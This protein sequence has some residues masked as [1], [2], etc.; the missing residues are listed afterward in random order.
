MW[1]NRFV[2]EPLPTRVEGLTKAKSTK[3]ALTRNHRRIASP[4]EGAAVYRTFNPGENKN[5]G[6][7]SKSFN[8][9]VVG[10]KEEGN[11]SVTE[12]K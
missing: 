10:K 3:K 12:K 9:R 7:P 2:L 8:I 5:K 11:Q 6:G 1:D 4:E